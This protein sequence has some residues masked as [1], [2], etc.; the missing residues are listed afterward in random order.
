MECIQVCKKSSLAPL[1]GHRMEFF[2]EL[3]AQNR[4]HSLTPQIG[5]TIKRSTM[6]LCSSRLASLFLEDAAAN[7]NCNKNEPFIGALPTSKLGI[8]I[9]PRDML[10]DGTSQYG[11]HEIYKADN[12]NNVCSSLQS[13]QR[14]PSLLSL[15]P[16]MVARR[17]ARFDHSPDS[18]SI[19]LSIGCSATLQ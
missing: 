1:H 11:L 15:P 18:S 12:R 14:A 16:Q 6:P 10:A 17:S 9:L 8:S 5:T 19:M 3:I 13:R 2:H 7:R 4:I